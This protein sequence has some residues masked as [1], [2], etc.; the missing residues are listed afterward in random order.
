M[1]YI[2]ATLYSNLQEVELTVSVFAG[3]IAAKKL[4]GLFSSTVPEYHLRAF[5]LSQLIKLH[6]PFLHT[7]LT[8][9]KV[10]MDM[11]YCEWLMTLFCG[12]FYTT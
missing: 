9:F 2:A 11:I 8:K 1:N 10:K 7:H 3:M 12:F 5:V 6:L 4:R